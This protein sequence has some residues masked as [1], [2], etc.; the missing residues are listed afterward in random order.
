MAKTKYVYINNVAVGYCTS[1]KVS[2][3][4]N[5]TETKT[6]DGVITDG[7]AE[8]S[9]TVEFEKIRYGGISS[10]INI[11]KLLHKM[12]TTPYP[13]K[14]VENVQT[15]EGELKIEQIIYNCIIDNK[16][17]SIDAEDRT[18]ESVSF[19]GSK[20]QEWVNGKEI[21]F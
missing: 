11:E 3:E 1:A 9:W 14:I 8:V 5:T 10:Y 21:P 17:Y 15:K 16:E 4:T 18:V 6:F 2:P 7:T 12:F 20:M 13:V 19:K